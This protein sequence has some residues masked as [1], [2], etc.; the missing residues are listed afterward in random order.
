MET[1][2][3][4]LAIRFTGGLEAAEHRAARIMVTDVWFRWA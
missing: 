4:H 1:S 3:E 2:R